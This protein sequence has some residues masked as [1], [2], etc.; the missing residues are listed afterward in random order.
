MQNVRK[1][2]VFLCACSV[3]GNGIVQMALMRRDA[4]SSIIPFINNVYCY[5]VRATVDSPKYHEGRPA[6]LKLGL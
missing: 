5:H 2:S 3:M 6:I 4:V 1:A